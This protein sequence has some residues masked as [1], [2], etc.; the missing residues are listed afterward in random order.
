VAQTFFVLMPVALIVIAV[1]RCE[2]CEREYFSA[3]VPR[4]SAPLPPC[5]ECE[6]KQ[7]LADLIVG[8]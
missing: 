4:I 5:P 1:V 2:R 6:G 7:V 8:E 3:A